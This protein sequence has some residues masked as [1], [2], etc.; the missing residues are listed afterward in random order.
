V[1]PARSL[2]QWARDGA[3]A[4]EKLAASPAGYYSMIF[5]DVQ[6]P[7]MNGYEASTAI[8]ALDRSDA[9]KIPIVAMTANAFAEDAMNCKKAGMNDHMA[10]P[11]DVDILI[12][13]LHTFLT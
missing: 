3:E 8:R 11:I 2:R 1:A 9:K 6:M 13:M 4:V 12:R 7:R 10:K 5:M